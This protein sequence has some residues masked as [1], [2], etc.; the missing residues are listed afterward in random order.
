VQLRIGEPA[1]CKLL[2]AALW[3]ERRGPILDATGVKA[4]EHQGEHA[5]RRNTRRAASLSDLLTAA[6]PR[7]PLIGSSVHSRYFSRRGG[8]LFLRNTW[9]AGNSSR[10]NRYIFLAER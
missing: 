3:F 4:D 5:A 10:T 9:D 6:L 1:R 8:S 2:G 7:F